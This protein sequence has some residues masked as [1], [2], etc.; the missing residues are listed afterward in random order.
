MLKRIEKEVILSVVFDED[1][2]SLNIL[3]GDEKLDDRVYRC[4]PT[5]SFIK[6]L[7]KEMSFHIKKH[8]Y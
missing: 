3:L 4:A 8:F 5:K 1:L 7:A 2:V 6:E